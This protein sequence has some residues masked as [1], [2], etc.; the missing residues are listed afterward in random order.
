MWQNS[1]IEVGLGDGEEAAVSVGL[2][3]E[4]QRLPSEDG[5]LPHE[6]PGVGDEEAGVLLRVNL[7]LVHVQH[8]RDHKA[9][10]DILEQMGGKKKKKSSIKIQDFKSSAT[11]TDLFPRKLPIAFEQLGGKIRH[12]S[13]LLKA[14]YE[15]LKLSRHNT[16]K[17]V[18]LWVVMKNEGCIFEISRNNNR[19]GSGGDH[20]ESQQQDEGHGRSAEQNPALELELPISCFA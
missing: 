18:S 7:P 11:M 6:L 13:E 3:G 5:E 12:N 1:L 10:I 14:G 19:I 16:E 9:N 8:A 15:Y 20:G 2:D 17:C 4:D